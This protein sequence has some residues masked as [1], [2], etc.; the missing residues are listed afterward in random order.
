MANYSAMIRSVFEQGGQAGGVHDIKSLPGFV[1]VRAAGDHRA[2]CRSIDEGSCMD[3]LEIDAAVHILPADPRAGVFR[4][5][6][7]PQRRPVHPVD[8]QQG[9]EVDGAFIDDLPPVDLHFR[10]G[11]RPRPVLDGEPGDHHLG[12]GS[13]HI[14]PHAQQLS[15]AP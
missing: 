5:H 9:R 7:P 2:A 12:G 14:Q 8:A 11:K 3:V 4:L 6:D 15:H 13:P 1:E 10:Y